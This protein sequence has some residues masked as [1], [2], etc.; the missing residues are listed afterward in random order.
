MPFHTSRVVQTLSRVPGVSVVGVRIL[1]LAQ[2]VTASGL[3]P[4]ARWSK[5]LGS[6]A[7]YWGRLIRS[8][9]RFREQ[10]GWCL[11]PDLEVRQDELREAIEAVPRDRLHVLDVGAGPVTVVGRRY[12]GKSIEVTA[13][14]PLADVYNDALAKSGIQVPVTTQRFSIE[15]LPARFPARSFDIAYCHNA[16]DHM[17]DPMPALDVMLS[18]VAPD[19][20]VVLRCLPDEGERNSYFGIHQWN[21][22]L[23]ESGLVVWNRTTRHALGEELAGQAEVV[24]ARMIGKWVTAIIRPIASPP[25]RRRASSSDA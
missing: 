21:V 3:S 6:E 17:P 4:S 7:G 1:G 20:F 8:P 10:F 25:I 11:D 15:D 14:D 9:D 13:I 5:H 22:D 23:D 12:A 24:S 2:R 19:G 18:L 16:I